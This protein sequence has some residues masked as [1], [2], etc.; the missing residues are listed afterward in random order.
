MTAR[1]RQGRLQQLSPAD[2]TSLSMSPAEH[3]TLAEPQRPSVL[4]AASAGSNQVSMCRKNEERQPRASAGDCIHLENRQIVPHLHRQPPCDLLPWRHNPHQLH[5]RQPGIRHPVTHRRPFT[6][7]LCSLSW[8]CGPRTQLPQRSAPGCWALPLAFPPSPV[9]PHHPVP[10]NALSPWHC[11]QRTPP[12][13][14]SAPGGCSCWAL[15][16]QTPP[17]GGLR[18]R[19]CREVGERGR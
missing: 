19:A 13:Q 7:T 11:G 17:G 16:L 12:P 10:P 15:L 2:D 5:H 3:F 1:S 14:Y 4:R 18:L 6:H 8:R 9:S